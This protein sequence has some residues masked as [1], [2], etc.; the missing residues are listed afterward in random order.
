MTARCGRRSAGSSWGRR[1]KRQVEIVH[2]VQ[3]VAA[4]S[5]PS[6][7]AAAMYR[8]PF[9]RKAERVGAVHSGA[10]QQGIDRRLGTGA[11]KEFV[12]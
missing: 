10:L 2:V 5:A 1:R 3:L 12:R 9:G 8:Q 4:A 7:L 6:E 11:M